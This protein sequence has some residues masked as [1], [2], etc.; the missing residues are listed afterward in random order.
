VSQKASGC[1]SVSSDLFF[2][3]NLKKNYRLFS[4]PTTGTSLTPSR[5][6]RALPI[7]DVIAAIVKSS[8]VPISTAEANESVSMLIKLC[9]FFVK[10]L[11]ISG[12]EWVEMPSSNTAASTAASTE[13]T[14]TKSK[15]N[16]PCSPGRLKGKEESTQEL[17]TRSPR[18]VKREGGGLREVREIIR[19][20]LDLQ[21]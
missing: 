7:S 14:P 5:K 20:E 2:I 19:K 1:K 6:R 3:F 21:D 9:P 13:G 4:N 10:K 16:V 8:P 17:V 15:P 12:K 18:R 11:H